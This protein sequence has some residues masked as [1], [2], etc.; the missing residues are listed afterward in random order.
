VDL[1]CQRR[2]ASVHSRSLSLSLSALRASLVSVVDRSPTRSLS[3]AALWGRLVSSVFSATVVDLHPC[4]C[5]GDHPRR[6]RPLSPLPHFAHSHPLSRSAVPAH[7]RRRSA[8]TLSAVQPA[9]SHAKPSR[10]PSRGEELVP[11]L[12]LPY[13]RLVLANLASLELSRAGSP[14]PHGD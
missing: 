2:P 9:I 3:L 14:C 1:T 12:S 5:R 10:A 8:A 6:P 7:A 13:F 11:V 4:T